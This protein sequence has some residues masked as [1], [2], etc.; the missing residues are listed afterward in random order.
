MIFNI[1]EYVSVTLTKRG[2]DIFNKNEEYWEKQFPHW[3]VDGVREKKRMNEGDVMKGQLWRL[4]QL[5]GE[6]IHLG[7]E[8]PFKNCEIE[9][10]LPKEEE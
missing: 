3:Y 10:H 1:N 9:M 4:F 2:A 8:V 6:H 7:G 5:F